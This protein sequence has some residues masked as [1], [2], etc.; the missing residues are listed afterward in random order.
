[1]REWIRNFPLKRQSD[2]KEEEK[3]GAVEGG[4]DN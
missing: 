4:A 3:G 1:M 2:D